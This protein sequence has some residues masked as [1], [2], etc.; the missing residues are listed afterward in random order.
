[1]EDLASIKVNASLARA[2]YDLVNG[3]GAVKNRVGNNIREVASGLVIF[4]GK[5]DVEGDLGSVLAG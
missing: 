2:I 4:G 5:E 1:M 3:E